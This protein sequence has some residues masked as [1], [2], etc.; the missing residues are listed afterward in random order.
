MDAV[1]S[2]NEDDSDRTS[3]GEAIEEEGIGDGDRPPG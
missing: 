2:E 3:I 1:V